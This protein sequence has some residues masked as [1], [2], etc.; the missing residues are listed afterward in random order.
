[1]KFMYRVVRGNFPDK[2]RFGQ[3]PEGIEGVN[4]MALW[5][6]YIPGRGRNKYK[7]PQAKVPQSVCGS[8]R[9]PV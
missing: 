8:A 2:I 6:K 3:D 1:M 7:D 4:H 5:G 9:K